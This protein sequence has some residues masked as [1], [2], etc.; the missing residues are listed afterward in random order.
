MKLFARPFA[1]ALL[2]AGLPGA[3]K[4]LAQQSV[5]GFLNPLNAEAGGLRL[6]SVSVFGGY[7]SGMV[8]GGL[9]SPQN[10]VNRDPTGNAGAV[11]TFGWSKHHGDSNFSAVYSGSYFT[12]VPDTQ[13]HSFNHSFN[14][15]TSGGRRIAPRWRASFGASAN[16]AS[17]DT[18]LYS[19]T[20]LSGIAA[21][22][23]TFDELA[24]G[25]LAGKAGTNAQLATAL[26]GAQGLE[27]A[28]RP[29]FYGNRTFYASLQ[30]SLSYSYSP[31]LTISFGANASRAQHL[32]GSQDTEATYEYLIPHTTSGGANV[33]V[34]YAVSPKTQIGVTAA[35]SRTFSSYQDAYYSSGNISASHV[36]GLHWFMQAHAGAGV[37]TPIRTTYELP[38][39]AQYTAGAS[40]GYRTRSHTFLA[41]GERTMGDT[42]A[43]GAG[44][45]VS[46]TGAWCWRRPGSDWWVSA[47]AG[48]QWLTGT[49]TRNLSGWRAAAGVGR[50]LSPHFV[51]NVQYSYVTYTN[52][53]H[54][55]ASDLNQ[56]GVFVAL[57]WSPRAVR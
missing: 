50:K 6:Y 19:P 2:L 13:W 57:V 4:L 28:L 20:Q 24:A 16:L 53:L 9:G 3:H 30:T 29:L 23:S 12:E 40:I 46:A 47:S 35:A 49:S 26:T 52:Y 33:S 5:I 39:G 11:A 38:R 25:L 36:M 42:Y 1:A 55:S 48:N 27:S 21:T 22:S 18:F 8:P 32:S 44:F 41:S 37:I 54:A 31:R 10:Y 45:G 43:Y 17:M 15:T 34:S 56:N 51:M 7:S 14:F